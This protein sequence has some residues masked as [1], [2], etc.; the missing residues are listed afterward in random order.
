MAWDRCSITY[1]SFSQMLKI[2]IVSHCFFFPV[3]IIKTPAHGV[4]VKNRPA[5]PGS[6]GGQG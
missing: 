6:R 5:G 4:G 2:L 3:E 1:L